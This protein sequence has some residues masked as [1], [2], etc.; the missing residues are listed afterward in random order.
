ML[1]REVD[2]LNKAFADVLTASLSLKPVALCILASRETECPINGA[3]C[4]YDCR[5]VYT[6]DH[7]FE[8]QL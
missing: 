6:E 8:T 4:L 1:L 2:N 5:G 3:F 7:S